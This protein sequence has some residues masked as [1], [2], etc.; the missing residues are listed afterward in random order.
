MLLNF[1][2]TSVRISY[3]EGLQ[4]WLLKWH[5]DRSTS[6]GNLRACL[7]WICKQKSLGLCELCLKIC[8]DFSRLEYA[9]M[10]YVTGVNSCQKAPTSIMLLQLWQFTGDKKLALCTQYCMHET[11]LSLHS[12][13]LRLLNLW[14]NYV[15]R[16]IHMHI[17]QINVLKISAWRDT[18]AY[19]F[20]KK[21]MLISQWIQIQMWLLPADSSY[22][23]VQ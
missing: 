17:L 23:Q 3:M 20:W 7:K 5:S 19:L 8:L 10:N 16:H 15:C 18:V 11:I 9:V 21:G 2:L 14:G 22:S 4:E 6:R 13:Y 12:I 1:A